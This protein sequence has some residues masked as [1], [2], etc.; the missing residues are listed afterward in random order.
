M[1]ADVAFFEN[2]SGLSTSIS[3]LSIDEYD[4]LILQNILVSSDDSARDNVTSKY[5]IWFLEPLQVYTRRVAPAH[6]QTPTSA[7]SPAYISGEAVTVQVPNSIN[8]HS[9]AIWKG[10]RACT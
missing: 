4:Y 6:M 1:F 9:I 2:Q 3:T 7:S 8:N 10:K 5:P